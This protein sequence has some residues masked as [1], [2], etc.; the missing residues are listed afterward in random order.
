M[1]KKVNL[2]NIVTFIIFKVNYKAFFKSR[3]AK[4]VIIIF[5]KNRMFKKQNLILLVFYSF[6]CISIS[7]SQS[8]NLEIKKIEGI[9]DNIIFKVDQDKEG[10]LWI[11][12][13]ENL[14]KYD[15]NNLKNY[16]LKELNLIP[17]SRIDIIPD[18]NG[19]IWYYGKFNF[20]I[21]IL[22]T[23]TGKVEFFR[24][25]FKKLPFPEED[26][27]SKL[28]RD[29]EYNIY[30]TVKDKGLYKY[31]GEKLS[32]VQEILDSKDD[33]INFHSTDAYDFIGYG[34]KIIKINKESLQKQTI[35]SP[36][37]I[38]YISDFNGE[39]IFVTQKEK[40][41][42]D[43]F[44]FHLKDNMLVDY[45]PNFNLHSFY[46]PSFIV[47]QSNNADNYCINLID[48]L[49]FINDQK[50]VLFEIDKSKYFSVNA[51]NSFFRDKSDNVWLATSEGLFKATLNEKKV[52][53]YLKEHSL[54]S[55]FKKD[56]VLYV[57][58]YKG[59]LASISSKGIESTNELIDGIENAKEL[60]SFDD[61]L[62]ISNAAN[63]YRYS[64]K[65]NK[66]I[67]FID[68]N[69]YN[70]RSYHSMVRHPKTKTIFLGSY[71]RLNKIDNV[72]NK[73]ISLN[74]HFNA[75]IPEV[76]KLDIRCFKAEGDNLWIGTS[77]G[78]FLM[79]DKED[80]VEWIGE[81]DGLSKGL[82][83][84][85]YIEDKNTIW[86][87][88]NGK[89]LIKW[90]RVNNSFKTF[91][92]KEGLSNNNV[93]A[94][95]KDEFGFFWLPTD[96][97]LNIFAPKTL[98]NKILFPKDGLTNKE[99]NYMSHFQDENGLLY[100]GGISGLNVIN[101]KDFVRNNFQED[102]EYKVVIN[103][104]NILNEESRIVDNKEG[105]LQNNRI[106][107]SS[108]PS[109]L[110]LKFSIMDFL[111]EPPLQSLYKIE[112]LHDNYI[113]AENDAISL[114]GLEPREYQLHIKVQS[115]NGQWT[116][117]KKT[118]IVEVGSFY[119]NM[120]FFILVLIVIFYGLFDISKRKISIKTSIKNIINS[121]DVQ[122]K[123]KDIITKHE[124]SLNDEK[125]ISEDNANPK[126]ILWLKEFDVLILNNIASV[127]FS[128]E[129]LSQ[130]LKISERQL[131][132]RI[133]RLTGKT[134]NKYITEIK[135]EEA[136]RLIQEGKVKSVKD[137]SKR[138]GYSTT[139]YFSKLFK[140]RFKKS[141][142][143]LM[144]F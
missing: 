127:N 7:F 64:F 41:K 85:I 84:D 58:T 12:S 26:I 138:V 46:A 43:F 79:N 57:G 75:F 56:S 3:F 73:V 86:I 63:L 5:N 60:L 36:Y 126:Y 45:L 81:K 1:L 115:N 99:F 20:E 55:I 112:P 61:K 123:E 27:I 87:A 14:T 53:N 135:L 42:P 49:V 34:K 23:Q 116:T 82:I 52:R 17:F 89:G 13:K 16:S 44:A 18:L 22:N 71:F 9:T 40:K 25:K 62:W 113:L 54:R 100:F 47:H 15:G 70:N 33:H 29:Q 88:T 96:N 21:K 133:K 121:Q 72:N 114:S 35:I 48:E 19:D 69:G 32:L 108:N 117:L 144:K 110:E 76:E 93:Y 101:P 92:Q 102:P 66:Y 103:S 107:I 83:Q 97:G 130:E 128:I 77:E 94:I 141:P 59:G 67:K 50:D 95:Y 78:L 105:L 106:N 143:D 30:I 74:N 119:V 136:Y 51:F 90:N 38:E 131:H 140:D 4:N 98:K 129:F 11:A 132:R 125:A 10:F 111:N 124:S 104:L 80:I 109:Y 68:E 122:L 6:F 37:R 118:I 142:S 65:A 31:D 139:D 24:E 8:F 137:L 91:T 28:Y 39:V 120:I 134:P 2:L